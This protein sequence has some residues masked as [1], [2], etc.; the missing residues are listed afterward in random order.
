[1][2]DYRKMYYE[3]FHATEDAIQ[4]LIKAHRCCEEIYESED[5]PLIL[6]TDKRKDRE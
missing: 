4:I 6:L 5:E 1:M 3:L 2:P